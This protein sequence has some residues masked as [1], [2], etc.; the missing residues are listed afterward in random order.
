[1]PYFKWNVPF[2]EVL[3]KC[4][5]TQVTILHSLWTCKNCI[6]MGKTKKGVVW[7]ANTKPSC[8]DQLFEVGSQI[9]DA[10]RDLVPLVQFAKNSTTILQFHHY[11]TNTATIKYYDYALRLCILIH[12]KDVFTIYYPLSITRTN[13]YKYY[14]YVQELLYYCYLLKLLYYYY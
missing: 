9:C 10:L 7:E 4:S 5:L 14:Y 6:K 13:Q 3:Q 12:N 1:M 11:I 2:T 8:L